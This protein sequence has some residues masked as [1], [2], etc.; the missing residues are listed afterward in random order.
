[1]RLGLLS[2]TALLAAACSDASFE[3]A[4]PEV[5]LGYLPTSECEGA[6]AELLDS[7]D[8]LQGDYRYE[9]RITASAGCFNS[10]R[11]EAVAQG[12]QEMPNNARCGNALCR[13]IGHDTMLSLKIASDERSAIW[14]RDKF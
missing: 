10:L 12:W 13:D 8:A 11:A 1:M 6:T 5:L 9:F 14:I 2:V 3:Q 4:E 7:E